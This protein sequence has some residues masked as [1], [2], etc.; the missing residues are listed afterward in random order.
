MVYFL[1]VDSGHLDK[2]VE[3]RAVHKKIKYRLRKQRRE[4]APEK[5]KSFLKAY[6]EEVPVAQ[7]VDN[8]A[9]DVE[10]FVTFIDDKDAVR[11]KIKQHVAKKR[12]DE[13]QRR[14]VQRMQEEQV[15]AAKKRKEIEKITRERK[16]RRMVREQQK[17]AKLATFL[18]KTKD[19]LSKRPRQSFLV[20]DGYNANPK[21][22]VKTIAEK[23]RVENVDK[24]WR[25]TARSNF[26]TVVFGRGVNSV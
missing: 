22:P 2:F 18:E 9:P 1:N 16:K 14:M 20:D 17:R 26:P 6:D 13:D 8:M 23:C 12:N 25:C 24:G 3:Q 5:I 4:H 19:E 21:H 11:F 10:V 15:N 7:I